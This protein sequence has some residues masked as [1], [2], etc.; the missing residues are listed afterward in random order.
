M[1]IVHR[2][3]GIGYQDYDDNRLLIKKTVEVTFKRLSDLC[4]ELTSDG[5]YVVI[6]TGMNKTAAIKNSKRHNKK[7]RT[8]YMKPLKRMIDKVL[9]LYTSGKASVDNCTNF[10][11]YFITNN[12]INADSISYIAPLLALALDNAFERV[13]SVRRRDFAD[14]DLSVVVAAHNLA[15]RGLLPKVFNHVIYST[16]ADF[17][18]YMSDKTAFGNFSMQFYMIYPDTG[19]IARTELSTPND[20]GL[21]HMDN[22]QR[23]VWMQDTKDKKFME[24]P[25][26][27]RI[28]RMFSQYN[29]IIDPNAPDEEKDIHALLIEES[30]KHF[31]HYHTSMDLIRLNEDVPESNIDDVV[32]EKLCKSMRS[33]H[34]YDCDYVK[35]ASNGAFV[36]DKDSYITHFERQQVHTPR[37]TFINTYASMPVRI[38]SDDESIKKY[39]ESIVDDCKT[40]L[41]L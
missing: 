10:M 24:L 41:H 33:F 9:E 19:Q 23:K 16:D 17:Y 36:L 7:Q 32:T 21:D 8:D 30:L 25:M 37:I 1:F 39:C 11:Q 4:E 26:R 20:K 18:C 5:N 14:V 34:G 38:P 40:V 22:R 29:D 6:Y 2:N 35:T 31:T 28:M 12:H 15:E 27:D 3:S 13:I